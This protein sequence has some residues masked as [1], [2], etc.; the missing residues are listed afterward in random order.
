[1]T[2]TVEAITAALR[3]F[4]VMSPG[5]LADHLGAETSA[6]GPHLKKMLEAKQLKATGVT[7]RRRVALP[8]QEFPT[9]DAPPSAP[10][11][12]KRTAGKKSNKKPNG[13]GTR[14][15][16]RTRASKP[17]A[18]A[19]PP[20][21]AAEDFTAAITADGRLVVLESG[22]QACIY[23]PAETNRIADLLLAHYEAA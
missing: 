4:G 3:K 6:L 1:M 5:E 11:K 12:K 22:Q 9:A 2:I 19:T 23:T 17:E 13:K 20:A 14:K 16:R 7:N 15:H 10:R 18:P 8:D 21:E